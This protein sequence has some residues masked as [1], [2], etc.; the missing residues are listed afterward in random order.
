MGNQRLCVRA[1]RDSRHAACNACRVL[2]R[3]DDRCGPLSCRPSLACKS[4][5]DP[6][7]DPFPVVKFFTAGRGA[8]DRI[9]SALDSE[10]VAEVLRRRHNALDGHPRQCVSPAAPSSYMK[11]ASTRSARPARPSPALTCPSAAHFLGV[12]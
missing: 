9:T 7:H 5:H 10:L 4:A 12:N 11:A 3:R 2:W 8:I 6:N 1:E